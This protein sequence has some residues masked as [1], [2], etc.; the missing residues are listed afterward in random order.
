MKKKQSEASSYLSTRRPLKDKKRTEIL[1]VRMTPRTVELAKS[2]LDEINAERAKEGKPR[3]TWGWY[4]GH[5]VEFFA[6]LL[7]TVHKLIE[8]TEDLKGPQFVTMLLK[9]K[10]EEALYDVESALDEMDSMI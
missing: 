2:Y 7:P 6:P 10:L 1:N 5:A 4:V 3:L 9:D 8:L